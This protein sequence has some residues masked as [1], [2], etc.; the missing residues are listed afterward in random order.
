[1]S[2]NFRFMRY[3]DLSWPKQHEAGGRLRERSSMNTE[4]YSK[5]V[6]VDGEVLVL[7]CWACGTE[8]CVNVEQC[9]PEE[10]ALMVCSKSHCRMSLFLVNELAVDEQTTGQIW[11]SDRKALF[12]A[13]SRLWK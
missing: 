5:T 2:V 4:A 13:L 9:T 3:R 7:R 6:R 8:H 12:A 10:L 1:M 11:A